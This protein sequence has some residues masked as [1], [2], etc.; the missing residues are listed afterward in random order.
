M[1]HDI[2]KFADSMDMIK[3]TYITR[4]QWNGKTKVTEGCRA[5][6]VRI[7][8]SEY[9]DPCVIAFG[10]RK[11]NAGG[12]DMAS[13]W[14]HLFSFGT[15]NNNGGDNPTAPLAFYNTRGVPGCVLNTALPKYGLS[16][17]NTWTEMNAYIIHLHDKTIDYYF[18]NNLLYS[19]KVG[20]MPNT[21]YFNGSG[22]GNEYL[23][24]FSYMLI[25]DNLSDG[26]FIRYPTYFDGKDIYG[27]LKKDDGE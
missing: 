3:Q 7:D 12:G 8:V 22:C 9:P 6:L 15:H 20:G 23:G 10:Y 2:W 25:G 27:I 5:S 24:V 13:D 26:L 17:E 19:M 21:F 11:W 18:N 1:V 14:Q 4:S 16:I